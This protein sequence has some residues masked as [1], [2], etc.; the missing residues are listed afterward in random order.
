MKFPTFWGGIHPCSHKELTN[1]NKIIYYVPQ[2][3]LV[4]PVSQHIGAPNKAVV[5]KGDAVFVGTTLAMTDVQMSAPVL[6][7][8]SGVVKDVALRQ[9]V[10]GNFEEC[11]I[12]D[13]DGQYTLDSGWG[14]PTTDKTEYISTIRRAGIVGYGGAT[15]PTAIKLT[16]PPST[17]ITHIILNGA[18]CEPY[19]NCDNRLMI[20]ASEEVLKGLLIVLELFPE[21]QGI[22]AIENN[23]QEALKTMKQSLLSLIQQNKDVAKVNILPLE[24][25]YPQGAEKMLIEAVTGKEYPLSCLPANVGCIIL[26]VRTA[27]Q[28]YRAIKLGEPSTERVVTVTGDAIKEPRNVRTKLGTNIKELIDFC[29]GFIAE[30]I[31]VISGGPMMGITMRNLDAP[32]TKATSGILA[33]T[34]QSAMIHKATPCLRC[35]KCVAACPMG[36][37]P[38]VLDPLV[39]ARKYDEFEAAGG[40]NCIEC[41]SCTYVCPACRPLTQTCRDG[42]AS[43]IA[44]RKKIQQLEQ[45]GQK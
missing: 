22:V 30:P 29:G 40:M 8:V 2:G 35:G 13:N 24:V 4:F 39:I 9:S 19:L 11:I 23:K 14:S 44:K 1:K 21:A 45:N 25:K 28:I 31:K 5:K 15:F 6:S 16:P 12:V 38:V 17:K 7:S 43:V 34:K 3:E 10:T 20:E 32:V 42:K 41:G 18:E 26:N 37:E 27:Q 36:L 33:L